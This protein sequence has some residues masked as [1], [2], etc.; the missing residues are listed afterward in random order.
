[1][2]DDPIQSFGT[3]VDLASVRV[4]SGRSTTKPSEKCE[5][6]QMTYDLIERRVWCEDCKRTIDNFDAFDVLVRHFAEMEAAAKQKTHRANEAMQASIVSRATKALDHVWRGKKMAP[7]CPHCRAAL[8]PEDF[9]NGVGSA[10]SR[11]IEVARRARK[12]TP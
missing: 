2:T 7:C 10:V 6:R 1:M 4:R 11:E 12:R 9:A 8:L 5:H 3:V